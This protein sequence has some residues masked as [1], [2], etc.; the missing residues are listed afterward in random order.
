MGEN[1]EP[2]SIEE[3]EERIGVEE[4]QFRT[5]LA[6]EERE[7]LVKHSTSNY[8]ITQAGRRVLNRDR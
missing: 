3:I 6:L 4:T 1:E 5:L 2:P 7:V 8:E